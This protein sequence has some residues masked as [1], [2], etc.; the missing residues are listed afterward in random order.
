[1]SRDSFPGETPQ[2]L[3]RILFAHF[4]R[5]SPEANARIQVAR[6]LGSPRYGCVAANNPPPAPRPPSPVELQ[7]WNL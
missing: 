2:F 7:R 3:R 6:Q 5:A 1:M 4:S